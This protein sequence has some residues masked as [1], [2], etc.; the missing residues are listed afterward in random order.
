MF[1]IK[2]STSPLREYVAYI[3]QQRF[4]NIISHG[5]VLIIFHPFL[6]CCIIDSYFLKH[7]YKGGRGLKT[8]FFGFR[9]LAL[10]LT[11]MQV[12]ALAYVIAPA[13]SQGIV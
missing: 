7:K 5:V 10:A 11:V 12:R 1:I 8:T 6:I 2:N 9:L 3:I 13:L 4:T